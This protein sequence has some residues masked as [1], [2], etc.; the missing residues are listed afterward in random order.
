VLAI[1]PFRLDPS[2]VLWRDG[3][4]V[5]LGRRGLLLLDKML[6]HRGEVVSKAE[7]IDAAWAGEVVEDSN[8][9]VQIA[10]L[11][12]CLGGEWIRTIERVG[13]QLLDKPAQDHRLVVPTLVIRP[14]RDLGGAASVTEAITDDLTTALARFGSFHLATFSVGL[15]ADYVLEG[16]ARY[17]GKQLQITVRLAE[18]RSGQYRWAERLNA[19]ETHHRVVGRIASTV[20]SQIELAEIASAQRDWPEAESAPDLYRR[21]QVHTRA[22]LPDD[23]AAAAALLERALARDP[24]NIRYLAA[25]CETIGQGICMGWPVVTGADA[26]RLF[27]CA[28]RG[29][30]QSALD[31]ETLSWLGFGMFRSADPA[32]GYGLMQRAVELNPHSLTALSLAGQA[33]MHWDSL[34]DAE[35]YLQRGLG[36]DPQHSFQ[37]G[38]LNGLA[39]IRMIHGQFEEALVWAERAYVANPSFGGTRWTLIAAN[40]QLGHAE[41]AAGFL[42][43]FHTDHLGVT[44]KTIRAG[45]P[46]RA[47]LSSTLEGLERAGLAHGG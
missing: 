39:R 14:F 21:A 43:R 27:D 24:D 47:R 20:E 42:D 17:E 10:K 13:Y 26:E 8:L 16:S 34:A 38:V 9:S 45:Q 15:A 2:G 12:K 46:T 40:A 4:P 28:S 35:A 3:R 44:I 11:R 33:A 25:M 1:G 5:P 36:L 30:R 29:L 22:A 6:K 32:L 31:A 41:V 23:Y 19:D 37:G 18:R 7:L